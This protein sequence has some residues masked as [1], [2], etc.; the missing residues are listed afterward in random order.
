MLIVRPVSPRLNQGYARSAL[1]WC[2]APNNLDRRSER[3]CCRWDDLDLA[4]IRYVSVS[5]IPSGWDCVAVSNFDDVHQ[6]HTT[7]ISVCLCLIAG[8]PH[9][10]TAGLV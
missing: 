9:G 10:G 2:N 7:S 8:I 4:R 1:P 5:R 3:N 6:L